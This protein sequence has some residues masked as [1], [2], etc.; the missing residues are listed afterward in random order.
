[1]TSRLESLEAQAGVLQDLFLDRGDLEV[2]SLHAGIRYVAFWFGVS[3]SI[4]QVRSEP[5]LEHVNSWV[6][7]TKNGRI[8]VMSS[9]E[10]LGHLRDEAEERFT[11]HLRDIIRKAGLEKWLEGKR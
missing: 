6:E 5:T 7:I 3:P 1:M 11:E 4:Q 10:S 9:R 2:R 8:Q